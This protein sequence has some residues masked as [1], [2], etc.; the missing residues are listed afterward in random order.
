[1]KGRLIVFEGL[2]GSGK[3]TQSK[4]LHQHLKDRGIPSEWIDCP[5]RLDNPISKLINDYLY[6]K[7]DFSPEALFMLYCTVHIQNTRKIRAWMTEGKTVVVDRYFPSA[8]AFQGA[9]G[10]DME[11]MRE[12]VGHFAVKAD[13]I[14]YP[15]IDPEVGLKR[16]RGQKEKVDRHEENM[17]FLRKVAGIYD[18]LVAEN[19]LGPWF[20]LDGEKGIE[21]VFSEVK[22]IV[23]KL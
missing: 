7:L 22:N 4:K 15:R 12:F 9:Q 18:E 2:D 1:M 11:T 8:L 23:G 16:K 21:E 17:G 6:K 5:G 20:V 19:V 10:V 14:I 3:R 13:A